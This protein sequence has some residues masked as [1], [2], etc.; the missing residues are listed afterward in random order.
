MPSRIFLTALE[1][2]VF[3]HLGSEALSAHDIAYRMRTDVRA[4]E[5][6]LNALVGMKILNKNNGLYSIPDPSRDLLD[7]NNSNY[8]GGTLLHSANLWSA[9]SHLTEVVKNGWPPPRRW[10]PEMSCDLA[11]SLAGDIEGVVAKMAM[12]LDCSSIKRLLDL[13]G[14]SG[15]FAIELANLYKSIQAV[16]YDNDSE[17]LSMAMQKIENLKLIQRVQVRKG[18]FMI[19]ELGDGYDMIS[20]SFILCLFNLKENT[21]LLKKVYAALE[22]G[23]RVI[24]RD[25]FLD[26]SHTSPVHS[27]VFAINMLVATLHGRAYAY[28]EIKDLL[29]GAGFKD[30]YKIPIKGLD[31]AVGRK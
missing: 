13:G 15:S 18:D 14:G 2:D 1:L 4:T 3:G 21:F 20:L 23:G 16:I 10:T 22:E 31:L 26:D 17:A 30:V 24:I 19:D 9:W 27:A 5:L 8:Y 25:A 12:V 29:E 28:S 11:I 7:S 6:L